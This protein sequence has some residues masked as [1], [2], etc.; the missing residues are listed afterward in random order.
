[1]NENGWGFDLHALPLDVI[2]RPSAGGREDGGIAD[3]VQ[4]S[5]F[6]GGGDFPDGQTFPANQGI[7]CR[8]PGVQ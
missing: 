7:R 1:M 5:V 8:M 3:R 2:L 4:G 6:E